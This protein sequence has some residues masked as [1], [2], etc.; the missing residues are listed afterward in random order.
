MSDPNTLRILEL[1]GGGERGY[2]STVFLQRFIQLWGINQ[3]DIW[4]NFDVICGT[5]VGAIVALGLACGKTIDEIIPFFTAQG[6]YVFTL[7]SSTGL[8][9]VPPFPPSPSI[10]PN[11]IQKGALI[12]TNTPF[13]SSSGFYKDQYGYGLL[14]ATLQNIFGTK[15][16]QDVLTNVIVP[17]YQ[18]TSSTTGKYILCSNLNYPDFVGQNELVSNVTLASGSAPVYLP[19]LVLTNTAPGT[20]NGTFIDG[21]I[22]Q[23]NPSSFGKT[24]AQMIKPTANRTCVLSLGTGIGEMGFDPGNPDTR[25]SRVDRLIGQMSAMPGTTSV[26]DT[27]QTIYSLFAISSFGGQESVA[28]SLFLES[29]YTLNQLYYYRFQPTLDPNIN[30]ELDNTD[31]VTL[32][33]YQTTATDYFNE[34]IENISNFI[35][36]LTA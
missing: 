2:L 13:Y 26:F 17:T 32:V 31:P 29:A 20:L 24:L 27:V 16:L 1:D 15:T 19:P 4:K 14:A 10:R 23:N 7:G 30:T 3:T 35:G 25:D 11:Y 5:S 28:K 6:P 9:P 8:P 36:H 33:Y 21:G 34:D 18:Q 22:Y 12:L